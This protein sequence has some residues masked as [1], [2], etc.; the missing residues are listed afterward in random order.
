TALGAVVVSGPVPVVAVVV[1]V[2]GGALA[3][4]L[5]GALVTLRGAARAAPAAAC[6][7]A[8]LLLLGILVLRAVGVLGAGG[9]GAVLVGDRGARLRGRCLEQE[10][11]EVPLHLFAAA[12]AV[13]V[14]RLLGRCA[15]GG[16]QRAQ[17]VDDRVLVRR[18]L[19][20]RA[21]G[22]LDDLVLDG[23][24]GGGLVRGRLRPGGDHGGS[25]RGA[26]AATTARGGGG[27]LGLG[28]GR[29]LRGDD[30]A[31]RGA[32]GFGHDGWGERGCSGRCA[33]AAAT[34]RGGRVLRFV[35]RVVL[36][37]VGAVSHRAV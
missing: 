26:G 1:A 31:R 29:V 9:L 37:F 34:A 10:R 4:V 18:V 33:G 13:L 32:L 5:G 15:A 7:G 6:A 24:L 17:V 11:G 14:H 27:G 20:R 28:A 2:L 23:R 25:G 21:R 35:R 22:V 16:G 36:G 8:A 12:R 30:G 3:G 19:V